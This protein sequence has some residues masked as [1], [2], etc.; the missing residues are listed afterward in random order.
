MDYTNNP[1]SPRKRAESRPGTR[2]P[3]RD[4]S[5][6]SHSRSHPRRRGYDGEGGVLALKCGLEL[7]AGE[8]ACCAAG[9]GF[10]SARRRH[11]GAGVEG[12]LGSHNGRVARPMDVQKIAQ[13]RTPRDS[14][15]E[16]RELEA[17]T[18]AG[19]RRRGGGRGRAH[20][21][22]GEG[23]SAG[24][25]SGP[26]GSQ[27]SI[28]GSAVDGDETRYG[29]GVRGRHRDGHDGA[30]VAGKSQAIEVLL[31]RHGERRCRYTLGGLPGRRGLV[32]MEGGEGWA[33]K[34]ERLS[35]LCKRCRAFR[36]RAC[37]GASVGGEVN[38]NGHGAWGGCGRA[39][40]GWTRARRASAYTNEQERR[41][42]GVWGIIVW[43]PKPRA[44]RR[45]R[46]RLQT[47]ARS[48]MRPPRV[49]HVGD[50]RALEVC[51]GVGGAS[52]NCSYAPHSDENATRLRG[53][54]GPSLRVGRTREGV[55]GLGTGEGELRRLLRKGCGNGFGAEA[56]GHGLGRGTQSGAM[57]SNGAGASRL[58][59]KL[60]RCAKESV[61]A[62]R[63]GW[64]GRMRF[65]H[66]S[67][68]RDKLADDLVF[69]LAAQRRE[70]HA[71]GHRRR[72]RNVLGDGG[73]RTRPN[74]F[75]VGAG[76][77]GRLVLR[78]GR[79]LYV[80]LQTLCNRPSWTTRPPLPGSSLGRDNLDAGRSQA[81]EQNVVYEAD[82]S[83]VLDWMASVREWLISLGRPHNP[84]VVRGLVSA[85]RP[86]ASPE[87]SS[88]SAPTSA[89][90]VQSID[91]P[92]HPSSPRYPFKRADAVPTGPAASL[93]KVKLLG[94]P[95]D[96]PMGRSDVLG[97][98]SSQQAT[99][100]S[101][102]LHKPSQAKPLA[103]RGLWLWLG[104]YEAK[105]K[106]LGLGFGPPE[107]GRP[108]GQFGCT[109]GS[110][111]QC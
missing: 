28:L 63:R 26:E 1:A 62:D 41:W 76:V 95:A 45:A 75:M 66:L 11:E 91:I 110:E 3:M 39:R 24:E 80:V 79:E 27:N 12:E 29:N 19:E 40:G 56:R 81:S 25:E 89:A 61:K 53:L 73:G 78:W 71:H 90:D 104:M 59:R 100:P 94:W 55:R 38:T 22:A 82:I 54:G 102:W 7:V 70:G 68:R 57:H 44:P 74:V 17:R 98:A 84:D 60:Y 42:Y 18:D 88:S 83:L 14:A 111:Y 43:D 69:A 99:K 50:L 31:G 35:A 16:G 51:G 15:R 2:L 87:P 48:F 85:N 58:N 97:L 49:V 86:P 32:K 46:A 105:A 64:S 8:G 106:G 21:D 101:P 37:M 77:G 36:K 20:V 10:G 30:G 103:S 23:T 107:N 13:P 33:L 5:I 93:K 9:M 67:S 109:I 72:G 6:A 34:T 108:S 96:L 52:G 92:F 4:T 47:R 65:T